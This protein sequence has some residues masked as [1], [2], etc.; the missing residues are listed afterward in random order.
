MIKEKTSEEQREI[1]NSFNFWV[2]YNSLTDDPERYVTS[3]WLNKTNKIMEDFRKE[4]P[5]DFLNNSI[6][7]N[8]MIADYK[9]AELLYI[10]KRVEEEEIKKMVIESNV[11]GIGITDKNELQTS[12]NTIHHLHH[13]IKYV[14]YTHSAI[15]DMESVL[16]WSRGYGNMAKLFK[17]INS[18]LTYN[19]V[20]L[21]LFSTIQY[22]YLSCIFGKEHVNLIRKNCDIEKGKINIIPLDTIIN[23]DVEFSVDLFVST[24][25]L[26]ESPKEAIRFLKEKNTYGASSFL[27]A[28]MC[29]DSDIK[30]L[31]SNKCY[32]VGISFLPEHCYLFK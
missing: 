31:I 27:M 32:E 12:G 24:W 21:K 9:R 4:L 6:I 3:F 19:I 25:A 14:D 2:L 17:R 23:G 29:C 16:E 18:N 8:T 13:I 5:Y 20:D 10:E 15:D 28:C 11:G 7:H 30:Y 1:F 26:S 22:I